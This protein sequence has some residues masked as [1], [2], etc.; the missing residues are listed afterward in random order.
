LKKV[1]PG[2]RTVN[3]GSVGQRTTCKQREIDFQAAAPDTE[4]WRRAATRTVCSF[5]RG[6]SVM[7]LCH[8]FRKMRNK[9]PGCPQD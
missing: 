7:G 9:R 2:L 8:S 6:R 5:A 3:A 1:G 4:T